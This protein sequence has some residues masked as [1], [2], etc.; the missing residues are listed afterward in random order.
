MFSKL[1]YLVYLYHCMFIVIFYATLIPAPLVAQPLI[2]QAY[3]GKI[4][5]NLILTPF[6]IDSS[7]T[8]MYFEWSQTSCEKVLSSQ[9]MTFESKDETNFYKE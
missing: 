8:S 4:L 5:K 7:A 2:W 9:F 6:L 3:T 1:S